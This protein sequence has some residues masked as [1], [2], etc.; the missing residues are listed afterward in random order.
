MKLCGL[1]CS[2]KS[3]IGIIFNK[4]GEVTALIAKSKYVFSDKK[5]EQKQRYFYRLRHHYAD[6]NTDFSIIQ[7]A[8][9]NGIEETIK[10]SPLPFSNQLQI[11]FSSL[12][13]KE[14]DMLIHDAQGKEVYRKM[15]IQKGAENI[16]QI[17]DLSIPTG[18]YWLT[19]RAGLETHYCK[20]IKQ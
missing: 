6:G 14:V 15:S 9:L 4:I 5:A 7:T 20:I 18:V 16:L 11:E 13:A 1:R 10:V 12:S 3:I 17:S 8:M 19:V 2:F